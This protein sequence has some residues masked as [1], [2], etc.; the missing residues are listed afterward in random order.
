[1]TD[2]RVALTSIRMENFGC[3]HDRTVKFVE[4]TNLLVG[5][6]ESGK[7]TIFTAIFTALFE[8]GVTQKKAVSALHNWSQ[9]SPFRLT[10]AFS[11]G[12][13]EY[14]LIRDYGAGADLMT[15]SDGLVYEGKAIRDKL[16]LYF[17]T[18]DRHLAESICS[19]SSDHP[20]SLERYKE[21]LKS[22]LETPLFSGFDRIKAVRYLDEQIKT[23]DNPRAH[24][25][26]EIEVINDQ[27]ALC[28]RQ[29]SDAEEH[30][31]TLERSRTELDDV[32]AS[33][34]GLDDQLAA[35]E[36]K[37]GGAE[38]YQQ[39]DARMAGLEERLQT[40]LSN[41]SKAVQ[42]S[43]E[44]AKI[45]KE[46][47]HINLPAP[48]EIEEIATRRDRL[49]AEVDESKRRMDTLIALRGKA[50]RSFLAATLLLA[51]LCLI[52]V[53]QQ[54]GY[55]TTGPAAAVFPYTIPVMVLVWIIR[56]GFYLEYIRAKKKATAFFRRQATRLDAMYADLNAIYDLRSADPIKAMLELASRRQTL[57][58]HF[59]NLKR[60]LALLSDDQG[61]PYLVK[62]KEQL[63]LEVVRINTEL[64]PLAKFAALPPILPDLRQ[65][66][67]VKRVRR[68]ALGERAALLTERCL[69]M[70]KVKQDIA[71]IDDEL[72]LLKRK[73]CDTG[74][75][76]EIMRI[77]LL[78]LNRSADRLIEETF[79]AYGEEAS[80]YL[81]AL[82][83]GKYDRLRF[84]KE[85][86]DFE[87]ALTA[88][89]RGHRLGA[90]LSS[91][92][93]D[94][95]YL[96]FRLAAIDHLGPEFA[97]PVFLDQADARLDSRRRRH[98]QS[99]LTAVA[100][101]RQVIAATTDETQWMAT[102][103]LIPCSSEPAALPAEAPIR[104]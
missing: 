15:D 72:E 6:N 65:E 66:S 90:Q 83:E 21:R 84:V 43:E 92:T 20:T 5:L 31:A 50:N 29:K 87:I 64:A 59:D 68:I 99:V 8:D 73:H 52:Y 82:T 103:H 16:S 88:A 47:T 70:A 40:H 32:Q 85:A 33:V 38:A 54:N 97:L 102:V 17:G 46:L 96:A 34:K 19:F 11:V 9:A 86:G 80:L 42:T 81:A 37:V 7:S 28:L 26:R 100:A 89:G 12:E 14:T 93:R 104:S 58:L 44:A 57:E 39:L 61:M 25:P 2:G 63:E 36:E 94:A 55:L 10:L 1:M 71:L 24:G 3:F 67:T 49:A 27:I 22:A 76:L 56:T 35:L 78:A 60:T 95:A 75:Q 79:V 53:V 23:L 91:S 51:F 18:A 69:V 62:N 74:E 98:L 101:K 45:E 4:G 48:Q 13:R 41:Y 77:T 30:L